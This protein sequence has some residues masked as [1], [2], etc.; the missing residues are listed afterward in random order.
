[1][2]IIGWYQSIHVQNYFWNIFWSSLFDTWPG[3]TILVQLAQHHNTHFQQD[4]SFF[5]LEK[6][7]FWAWLCLLLFCVCA[8]HLASKTS[9]KVIYYEVSFHQTLFFDH[10][11]CGILYYSGNAISVLI[12]INVKPWHI[13]N[14]HTHA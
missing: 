9:Y 11:G 14:T 7:I 6:D 2:Y 13:W 12:R 3:I 5:Q 1:M 10:F 8:Y 4:I